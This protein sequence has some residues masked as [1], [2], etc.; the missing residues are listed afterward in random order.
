ME[1]RQKNSTISQELQDMSEEAKTHKAQWKRESDQMKRHIHKMT[2]THKHQVKG[3]YSHYLSCTITHLFFSLLHCFISLTAIELEG[4]VS[5][6]ASQVENLE[7]GNGQLKQ[8]VEDLKQEVEVMTAYSLE[9]LSSSSCT[10]QFCGL[11][12]GNEI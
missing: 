8:E 7:I 9:N 11:Q 5:I 3:D 12:V 6:K 2:S 1:L 10:G 4:L